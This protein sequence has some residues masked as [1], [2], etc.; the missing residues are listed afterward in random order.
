MRTKQNTEILCGRNT[1]FE[2]LRAGK[3][4]FLRVYW[5]IQSRDTKAE[6]LRQMI[7]TRKI[8]VL[9]CS[10][11]KIRQISGS[12]D[13]QGIALEASIFQYADLESVAN[14][15]KEDPKGGFLILLDEI[16]DPH[17]VGALIRTA[18]LCGASGLILLKHRQV[19]VTHTV[20]KAASGAQEYLPI[21]QEVN[22]V[23]VINYLKENG[24]LIWGA[25][26]GEGQ[27]IFKSEPKFPLALILGSEGRGLRRL[28]RENCDALVTIPMEGVLDSF[29]VSV[30]G[31]ILMAEI[32]KNRLNFS[33]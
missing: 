19:L 22:L 30:A 14:K 31:G 24:F 29:N 28:V 21:V 5:G 33:K 10:N 12:E 2:M 25:A 6:E 18:H 16:Q 11:D 3:R 7:Q 13:H 1:V 15:A 17:N 23:N 8:P 32:L 20:C 9:E 4:K 26:G 27:S